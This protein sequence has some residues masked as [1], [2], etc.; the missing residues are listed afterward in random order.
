M[1]SNTPDTVST[2]SEL[3]KS[4]TRD[5]LMYYDA[6]TIAFSL[7]ILYIHFLHFLH[8]QIFI[9][10]HIIIVRIVNYSYLIFRNISSLFIDG[11]KRLL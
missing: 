5:N 9:I 11:M 3:I 8:F 2:V 6:V 4:L 10:T 7:F 1:G